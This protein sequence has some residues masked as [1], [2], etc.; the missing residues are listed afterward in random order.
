MIIVLSS[1]APPQTKQSYKQ[2][3]WPMQGPSRFMKK[4]SSIEYV[5]RKCV[6]AMPH[7]GW[8][9]RL[10]KIL[11][12]PPPLRGPEASEMYIKWCTSRVISVP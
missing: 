11:A 9:P 3:L 6:K 5:Y 4:V 12:I 8:S 7:Y 1:K 10:S 2:S